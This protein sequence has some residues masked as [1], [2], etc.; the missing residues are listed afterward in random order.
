VYHHGSYRHAAVFYSG[1]EDFVA[2]TAPFLRAAVAAD[3]PALVV[4]AQEKIDRL[5]QELG[6][7]AR[8]IEFADMGD[9][10]ANPA[11]IIPAWEE[12]AAFHD[13]RPVRG[14]GEPIF[15]ERTPA[16]LM[17]CQHHERLLNPALEG[18]DLFLICPYDTDAL[19]AEV[20]DEARRSH[21]YIHDGADTR[22]SASF[23]REVVERG[24]LEEPL[25]EPP[26]SARAIAFDVETL[27]AVRA[28]VRRYAHEAGLAQAP[29]DRLVLASGELT[30]NSV[31]HGGGGGT[32]RL[33]RDDGSLVCEITDHGRIDDP[34]LDRRRPERDQ[35]GGWGLWIANQACDLL[36]LRSL[37]G[38]TVARLHVQ[39]S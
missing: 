20:V 9:V 18:S 31:R 34:L 22:T 27:P 35:L 36:Q 37:P 26:A 10:G 14:I 39:V 12:F 16:Q 13:G 30:S 2:K 17:E 4:V 24:F 8:A 25:P 3:E 7:D 28:A 11:R 29:T 21:P 19:P 32:M 33:W 15:P 6:D 1:L 5:Q 38:G 23:D